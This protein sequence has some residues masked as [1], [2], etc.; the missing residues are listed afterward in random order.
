MFHDVLF[1]FGNSDH[2]RVLCNC[3][4]SAPQNDYLT[5]KDSASVRVFTVLGKFEFLH[6]QM[7]DKCSCWWL[8][9][10]KYL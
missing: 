9:C 1:H 7:E 6:T 3:N 4:F 2:Q 5:P 8:V 10:F